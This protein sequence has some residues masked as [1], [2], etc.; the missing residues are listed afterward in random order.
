M[1]NIGKGAFRVNQNLPKFI[2]A[3]R[4]VTYDV[5]HLRESLIEMNA[6]L[7]GEGEVFM[8]FEPSLD[9][10]LDLANEY[11][12]EDLSCGWGHSV[13]DFDLEEIYE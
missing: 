4:K 9:E 6:I 2:T 12:Q 1:T 11:A 5:E 3:T 10:M 13:N 8:T 7:N